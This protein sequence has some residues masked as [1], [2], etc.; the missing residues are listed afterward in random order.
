MDRPDFSAELTETLHCLAAAAADLNHPWW[1][2]GSTAG[3]LLGVP[4][5]EPDDVDVLTE[6]ADGPHLLA[7]LGGSV[8]AASHERFRSD[9]FGRVTSTPRRIDVMSGFHVKSSNGWVSV[10]PETRVVLPWG[11]R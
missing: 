9:L 5:L 4:G 1:I 7:R 2:L 11:R 3:A 6:G 8:E 10:R